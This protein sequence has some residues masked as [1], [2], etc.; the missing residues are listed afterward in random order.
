MAPKASRTIELVQFV[1]LK[2]IDP[3]FYDRPYYL[4][5]EDVSKKAYFLLLETLEKS[6]KV[7]IGKFVMHKKEYLAALRPLG[8]VLYLNTMHF[9]DEII[10]AHEVHG[11]SGK[12]SAGS[13]E[14]KMAEQLVESLTDDF[15]PDKFKDEYREAVM[16]L[17]ERKVEGKKVFPAPGAEEPEAEVVD[18]MTA[19]K[20]SLEQNKKKKRK[21][22]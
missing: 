21:A 14:I 20:A 12:V 8:T 22:A 6:N 4:L 19:L 3:L 10:S 7:G 11:L 18:L 15:D 2:Q 17:V 5:P 13:S 16:D 1:D 9:A